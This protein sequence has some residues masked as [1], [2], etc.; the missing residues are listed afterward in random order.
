MGTDKIEMIEQYF[1]Y[2]LSKKEFNTLIKYAVYCKK[3]DYIIE[4]I[5][6]IEG[7]IFLIFLISLINIYTFI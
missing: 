5:K 6:Q 2:A 3:D 4:A 1:A 7:L